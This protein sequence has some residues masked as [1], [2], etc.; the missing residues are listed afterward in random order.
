VAGVLLGWLASWLFGRLL[1]SEVPA[2]RVVEK[3][4]D[5]PVEKIVERIVEKPVDRVVETVVEK[6]VVVEKVVERVVETPVDRIIDRP[7]DSPALLAQLAQATAAA[8]LV[9]ALRAQLATAE[10]ELA[11]LRAP[12]WPAIDLAAA[13]AAGFDIKAEDD[14]KVVEGI[15][16]KIEQLLH[17]QGIR[18]FAQLAQTPVARLQ[19]ILD[20]AGPHYRIAD[21]GTWP[22]QSLLCARNEWTALKTLQDS[23]TAGRR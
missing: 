14:L 6:P 3:L 18:T 23:L 5:R 16:P 17:A 15:G 1:R 12:A 8:A 13:R 22:E 11:R 2:P 20:A 9:P 19:E 7:V 4:V 21:P 10:A